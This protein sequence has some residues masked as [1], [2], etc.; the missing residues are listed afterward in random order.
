MFVIANE[1]DAPLGALALAV[2]API[3]SGRRLEAALERTVERGLGFVADLRGDRGH[4]EARRAQRLRRELFSGHGFVV[5]KGFP[6]ERY[7]PEQ[8]SMI[9]WG[10]GSFLGAALP[11]NV[12][13]ERLTINYIAEQLRGSYAEAAYRVLPSSLPHDAAV[14]VRYEN[15]DTQF[16]MPDG[17]VGLPQF[18]RDAWVVGATYWP[19]PD[20]ALKFDQFQANPPQVHAG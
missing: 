19:D 13:G 4:T 2:F 20:V 7:T 15:F 5:I 11:Q 3:A 18:D 12:K 16:R 6:V 9:Y 17:F 14:F 8:A 1:Y 10:V